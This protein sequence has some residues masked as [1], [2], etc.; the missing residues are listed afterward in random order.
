MSTDGNISSMQLVEEESSWLMV[1]EES[2]ELKMLSIKKDKMSLAS[3]YQQHKSRIHQI[4][5][6]PRLKMMLS[7]DSHTLMVSKLA[8]AQIHPHQVI[9][10]EMHDTHNQFLAFSLNSEDHLLIL[11]AHSHLHLYHYN[12]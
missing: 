10:I 12:R 8:P 2:G 9:A 1:G 6:N 4:E 5:Y 3:T 7:L 11:D